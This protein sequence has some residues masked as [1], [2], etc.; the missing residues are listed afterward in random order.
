[1]ENA[2]SGERVQTKAKKIA[3]PLSGWAFILLGVIGL[4]LPILQGV[5]FLLIGLLILSSEYVWAHRLLLKIRSR[6]PAMATRWD[7]AHGIAH[8]WIAKVFRSAGHPA[9]Q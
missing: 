4:F 1:V 5:L 7:E 9:R 6:F 3:L 2:L 8:K